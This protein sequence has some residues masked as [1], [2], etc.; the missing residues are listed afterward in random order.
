[1]SSRMELNPPAASVPS[2][3]VAAFGKHPGWDD[4]IDDIGV[5]T[6]ELVAFKR[7]LYMDG[8]GGNIDAGT[9]DRLEEGQRLPA[10][11]HVFLQWREGVL[12]VGRMWS[13][14]DGKGRSRYPMVV[15]AQCS[16][17]SVPWAQAEVL[18]KLAS[19]EDQCKTVLTA[20]E[21]MEALSGTGIALRGTLALAGENRLALPEWFSAPQSLAEFAGKIDPRERQEGFCRLLYKIERDLTAYL[22]AGRAGT[23]PAPLP[24]HLRVPACES[25]PEQS[26]SLWCGLLLRLLKPAAPLMLIRPLE[27]GWVDVLAGDPGTAQFYCLLASADALPKTTDIPYGLDA[28]FLEHGAHRLE[29]WRQGGRETE[30]DRGTPGGKRWWGA[31]KAVLGGRP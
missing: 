25:A 7:R 18:P 11:H 9:W 22:P 24:Q 29:E 19:A 16:G 23:G 8:I 14:R 26:L 2:V 31:M 4:H 3:R 21:V 15:C 10:F 5:E 12:I 20:A 13:S 6:N 30:S 28:A 1:V 17:V 27:A